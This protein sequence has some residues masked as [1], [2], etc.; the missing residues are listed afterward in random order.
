MFVIQNNN[1]GVSFK[2]RHFNGRKN[3]YIVVN[4]LS[5]SF[6]LYTLFPKYGPLSY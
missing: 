6:S 4:I 5:S 3:N 2:I 1:H